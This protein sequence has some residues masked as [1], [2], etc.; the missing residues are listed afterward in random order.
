MR[1]SDRLFSTKGSLDLFAAG[2]LLVLG[3]L[4]TPAA[5]DAQ[6]RGSER[7]TVS[8]VSDGTTVTIE[9]SRPHVRGRDPVFGGLVRWGHTWTPGANHAT[10]FEASKD[11]TLNDVEVPAG[12]YS[13]WMVPEQGDWEVVLDPKHDLYHTR[14][15]QPNED[16]IRFAVTPEEAE[17]TE[18]LT[19]DFP[20]VKPTGMMLRFR[21]AT[22]SV[23]L[24][25]LVP[26]S[27]ILVVDSDQ[28]RLL[29][30]EYEM[31]FEG[32]PPPEA[33]GG[34]GPPPPMRVAVSYEGDRLLGV[35]S[36]GP[37]DL[38]NTFALLPVAKFVFNPAWME[39]GEVFETE[40][41]MYFEF[42]VED[43]AASGFDVRGL[44]DRL[45]MRGR[46]VR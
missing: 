15:P 5:L 38:P 3:G 41:D 43:A 26:P 18:A 12:R 11:V 28:A 13:V 17:F 9:Y 7:A 45:M 1:G 36:D 22:S 21:W 34:G 2:A 4:P 14:A 8:Q 20:M 33:A 10:T 37:P 29:V 40:V 46:R 32:P 35:I 30:G 23:P 44:E 19:W 25:V 42:D 16:Q 31:S 39:N 6:V 27:R 24:R